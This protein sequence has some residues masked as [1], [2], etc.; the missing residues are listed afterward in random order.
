MWQLLWAKEMHL[1]PCGRSLGAGAS[2]DV[3]SSFSIC[4]TSAKQGHQ[5]MAQRGFCLFCFVLFLASIVHM[6]KHSLGQNQRNTCCDLA[7][8]P[9][10]MTISSLELGACPLAVQISLPCAATA[11][12]RGGPDG[13]QQPL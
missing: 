3:L 5:K 12:P 11:I 13:C 10:Q 8:F 2:L 4:Q 9:F 1:L 6:S 7:P